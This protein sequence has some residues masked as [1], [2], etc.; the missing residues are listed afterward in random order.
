MKQNVLIFLIFS[1]FGLVKLQSCIAGAYTYEQLRNV[2]WN[3]TIIGFCSSLFS[4][5]DLIVPQTT[6]TCDGEG[7][8]F[9]RVRAGLGALRPSCRD[10]VSRFGCYS[11]LPLIGFV[12]STAVPVLPCTVEQ[13]SN[14]STTY[15]LTAW[16]KEQC[17]SDTVNMTSFYTQTGQMDSFWAVSP[18]LLPF[19]RV[20]NGPNVTKSGWS[21]EMWSCP[22]GLEKAVGNDL[23]DQSNTGCRFPCPGPFYSESEWSSMKITLDV[24]NMFSTICVVLTITSWFL[25]KGKL[26]FPRNILFYFFIS[27]LGLHIPFL[28]GLF[29]S[30]K[31]GHEDIW[32]ENRYTPSKQTS[33]TCGAQGALLTY[34][35]KSS[36][37]WWFIILFNAFCEYALKLKHTEDFLKY[38]LFFGFVYPWFTTIPPLALGKMVYPI[39]SPW[40]FIDGSSSGRFQYGFF[41]GEILL[42]LLLGVGVGACN[43]FYLNQ[44]AKASSAI[45]GRVSKMG[46]TYRI[47][48]IAL[49][50]YVFLFLMIICSFR[51]DLSSRED[52]IANS[53][54]EWGSCLFTSSD[55]DKCTLKE[56]P[57]FPLL[58]IALFLTS[59]GGLFF[60]AL[61]VTTP[62]VRDFWGSVA[63]YSYYTVLRKENAEVEQK[64][65]T[66]SRFSLKKQDERNKKP[67]RVVA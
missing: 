56:K 26:A 8:T 19:C 36:A 18:T 12:A 45:G 28:F 23:N 60:S 65:N 35:G 6:L 58:Y 15:N 46:A 52:A 27:I 11:A 47:K 44:G 51:M 4:S 41:Y 10:A 7:G 33:V 53:S 38:Y 59:C 50:F 34:W 24:L 31:G 54:R 25:I 9:A 61:F 29:N 43:L 14:V 67:Q 16:I 39:G 37:V 48:V 66:L 21:P 13:K 64:L 55:P 2:T 63:V 22:K 20:V 49:L 17:K 62:D 42:L 40:C 57:L 3:G 1:L 30:S 5:T 32:C